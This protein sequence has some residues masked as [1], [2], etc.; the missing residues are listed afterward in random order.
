MTEEILFLL[1]S[2]LHC[3]YVLRGTELRPLGPQWSPAQLWERLL[4]LFYS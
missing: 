2:D 1:L 3:S 4:L